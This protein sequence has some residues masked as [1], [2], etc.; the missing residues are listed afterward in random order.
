[1]SEVQSVFQHVAHPW[2][3]ARLAGHAG[4]PPKVDDERVGWNGKLGLFITKSLVTL[5]GGQ[6]WVESRVG[7]GTQFSFTLPLAATQ[8]TQQ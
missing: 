5:H 6:M 4:A 1:M 3:R 2:T 7:A 8:P